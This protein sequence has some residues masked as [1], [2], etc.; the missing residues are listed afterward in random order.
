VYGLTER[1]SGHL[2]VA[3]HDPDLFDYFQPALW[4][5]TSRTSLSP[6]DDVFYTKTKDNINIV[7]KVSKLGELPDEAADPGARIKECGY[8]S[9]FEEFSTAFALTRRG[10]A[11]IYPRA[12]YKT[13]LTAGT[14]CM[15]DKRR[16][17]SHAG[18]LTPEGT[19][20]LQMDYDYITVWGFWNGP[21]ESLAEHDG[22]F[23]TGINAANALRREIITGQEYDRLM[24][25][26]QRLLAENGMENL[27]L[28]GNHVLLSL[29]PRGELMRD[30]SN[31]L[32]IRLCNFETMHRLA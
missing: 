17:E 6:T 8:N 2:W 12:I 18:I 22:V 14:G 10:I 1:T 9:P 16:Y 3:G 11:T 5:K 19:P 4:R 31:E 21:D 20:V 27:S 30:T 29:N 32:D 15:A 7:W 26:L 24:R 13:G 28:K 25:R 23:Y